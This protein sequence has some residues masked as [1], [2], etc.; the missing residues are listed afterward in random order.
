VLAAANYY[1]PNKKNQY[2]IKAQFFQQYVA[3]KLNLADTKTYTRILVLVMQNQGALEVFQT[4]Q[5]SITFAATR[6]WPPAT[7]QQASL[8]AGLLKVM[9]KRLIK[10]SPRAEIDWLKKRL[11]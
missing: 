4:K 5:P 11:A 10:L 7:Y 2:L 1:S 9:A 6:N 3:D 8:Y